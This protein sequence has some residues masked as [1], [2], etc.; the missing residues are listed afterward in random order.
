MPHVAQ[1]TLHWEGPPDTREGDP[2]S[3]RE[4]FA[5]PTTLAARRAHDR[6]SRR[7]AREP[8]PT[9]YTSMHP[10]LEVR[11]CTIAKLG[12]RN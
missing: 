4:E 5:A 8:I 7:G 11:Q 6:D 3:C 10:S 2:A 1:L 9:G 12:T